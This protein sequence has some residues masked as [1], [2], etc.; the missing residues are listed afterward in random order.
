MIQQGAAKSRHC[1]T[2]YLGASACLALAWFFLLIA[3]LKAQTEPVPHLGYGFNVAPWDT[4]LIESM[5]FNWM[6][7]FDAPGTPQPVPILL[8]VGA[9]AGDMGNLPAFGQQ[10]YQLALNNGTYIDAYE[11][12]NEVNLDA[13]YGW[14]AA[15]IAAD[16][17][18]LLCVAYEQIKQA[19]PT[20]IVVSA[21]LAP[22]GRVQ[23]NWNG[24]PGHNGLYQDERE[25]LIE[26]LAA[27]G[28]N[29]LDVV[30]YHPYGFSADY[31]TEPDIPSA[32]PS[33]NCANGFCF[34]GV[35]KFY[36]V[37]QANGAADKKLWATEFG[38]IVEP[39]AECLADPS[40]QGRLWQI[41]S[42]AKQASNLQGAFQYADANWPWMGAMFI[43][44]LN[45]NTS[46][47]YPLCEQMRYYGVEGRPAEAALA[48]M[49][50]NPATIEPQLLAIPPAFSRLVEVNEQ[51]VTFTLPLNLANGGWQSTNYTI[52]VDTAAAVVPTITNATGSLSPTALIPLSLTVVISQPL[53]I[54]TGTLIV[55]ASPGTAG[56]PQT[57]PLEVR[58]LPELYHL[59][60]PA[61]TK[62]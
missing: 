40:W 33:Q 24:H 38:W 56:V 60:L 32:D 39:P 16:Y 1:R 10:V 54:Y 35:E 58:V 45:F 51:P 13:S 36:E 11:I 27:G 23:G 15:P 12:G 34:R 48:A 18:T 61:I 7:V 3:A 53:G 49:P 52:T 62:P 6:K 41:V 9:D 59:Y 29:C 37:M 22:T 31:D 5:G 30:G 14:N 42:E 43:F 8:R 19:D 55:T 47:W 50:K 17:A 57:V 28:E 44:N 20:A 4:A 21:G 26:F 2:A 46:G 25:Y